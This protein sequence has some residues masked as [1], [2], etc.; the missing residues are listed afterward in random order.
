[1]NN[2][3]GMK[4][5]TGE[6]NSSST[7][8]REIR[9]FGMI[10]CLFFGTLAGLGLWREKVLLSVFFSALAVIGAGCL[11]LPGPMGP[12]YRVWIAVAHRIGVAVTTVVL[13]LAYVGV[14]T[15]AALLKRVFGGRPLPMKP[16]SQKASYWNPRSEPAQPKDRFNKRY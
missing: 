16:D 4:A 12:V 8:R 5:K 3:S 2:P 13:T 14:I 10:A 1:M 11:L 9:K 7:D 6:T 15:P